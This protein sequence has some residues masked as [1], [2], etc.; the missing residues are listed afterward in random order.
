M[1]KKIVTNSLIVL[2][3]FLYS[4]TNC[5]GQQIQPQ[6]IESNH[7]KKNSIQTNLNSV[8]LQSSCSINYERILWQKQKVAYLTKIGMG[9]YSGWASE[10]S[11][12][13]AKGGA[14]IGKSYHRLELAGG[15]IWYNARFTGERRLKDLNPIFNAGWRFQNPNKHL[16]FRAGLSFPEG[17]YLGVGFSF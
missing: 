9:K 13:I 17:I 4:I 12:L 2:I 10:G 1:R 6:L 3:A 8:V 15:V 16:S 7:P 11:Y 14:L 5:V